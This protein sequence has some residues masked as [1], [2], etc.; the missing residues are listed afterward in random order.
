MFCT[1][2]MLVETSSVIHPGMAIKNLAPGC[3][4]WEAQLLRMW[5]YERLRRLGKKRGRPRGGRETYSSTVLVPSASSTS[6]A[7]AT[8]SHSSKYLPLT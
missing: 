6:P 7:R 2:T 1:E 4:N 3:I 5:I 8:A